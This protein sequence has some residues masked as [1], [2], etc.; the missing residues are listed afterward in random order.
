[1][2]AKI[3]GFPHGH[4]QPPHRP[5]GSKTRFRIALMELH[6]CYILSKSLI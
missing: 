3:P 1:L 2:T 6:G 5:L 4:T